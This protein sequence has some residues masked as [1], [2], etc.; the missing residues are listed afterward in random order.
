MTLLPQQVRKLQQHL[1]QQRR[2]PHLSLIDATLLVR[3]T[4]GMNTITIP[5]K[6]TKGDELVVISKK[7]Y[8]QY[9]RAKKAGKP[10]LND[11]IDE[12]LR[13]LREGRVSPVFSS[14]KAAIHYLQRQ[15]KKVR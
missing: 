15:A 10:T 5:K 12:G 11:A 6:I 8:E 2:A 13:D 3:Y 7:E 4:L 9:L 1:L 14:A